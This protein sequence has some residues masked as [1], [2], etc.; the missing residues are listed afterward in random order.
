MTFFEKDFNDFFNELY[1]NNNRE[2]FTE[3]KKRYEK[4]VKKPFEDFISHMIMKVKELDPDLELT[5]KEA[6]FRIYR[7]IRFSKDKTPY[8]TQVSAVVGHGGRKNHVKPGM[9]IQLG[10]EDARLYCGAYSPNKDQLYAIRNYIVNHMAEFNKELNDTNFKKTFGEIHGEKNKRLP[11]EFVEAANEQPLL[12]NKAF[13]FFKKYPAEVV[14][15]DNLDKIFMKDYHN[16][17]GMRD[18]LRKALGL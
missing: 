13:Y 6:I 5:P 2:W 17:L 16:G 1:L 14:Q 4:S 7:D 11:K 8:K 18:F 10:Q 3:N 9:Y 15:K 12:F